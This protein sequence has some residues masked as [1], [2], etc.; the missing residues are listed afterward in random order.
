MEKKKKIL[1]LFVLEKV[2]AQLNLALV[3][4]SDASYSDLALRALF[5]LNNHNYVVNA[6]RRSSLIELLLLAEPSAEQTYHDLL[7]KDRNNYVN[8]TF[9]KARSYLE[10]SAD[11]PGL[12]A[13][14]IFALQIF[15]LSDV[16]HKKKR[17]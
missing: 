8:T 15:S 16:S 2:L 6:L 4:K 12:C 3:S 14:Q 5:R 13:L 7:I 9:A 17:V 10:Q 11:E 1:Y